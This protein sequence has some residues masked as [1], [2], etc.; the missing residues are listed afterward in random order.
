MS[1]VSLFQLTNGIKQGSGVNERVGR[2]IFLKSLYMRGFARLNRSAEAFPAVCRMALVFDKQ[3]NGNTPVLGD[4]FREIDNM[5]SM[6]VVDY[7]SPMNINNTARF[8]ILLDKTFA[9]Q[10]YSS[11]SA[12][13]DNHSAIVPIR[14]YKKLNLFTQ[15]NEGNTGTVSDISSGALYLIFITNYNNSTQDEATCLDYTVRLRYTD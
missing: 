7:S 6:S 12:T 15:F 13:D 9:L 2:K 5:G 10:N 8:T 4:I 1:S 3:S 11:S 14:F